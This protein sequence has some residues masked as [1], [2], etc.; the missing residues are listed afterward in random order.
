MKFRHAAANRFASVR[1]CNGVHLSAFA[2]AGLRALVDIVQKREAPNTK[3]R[4]EA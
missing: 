1:E 4:S 3:P 2:A